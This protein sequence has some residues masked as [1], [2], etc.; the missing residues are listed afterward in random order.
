MPPTL[1]GV[2][3]ARLDALPP[4]ERATLAAGF[5]G[6]AGV[7]G[8][9]GGAFGRRGARGRARPNRAGS[10]RARLHPRD[11]R[12]LASIARTLVSLD[13]LLKKDLTL[14]R[15][16]SSF[17]GTQE[18][19]FKHALLHQ[20]AYDSVLR[21]H[22]RVYHTQAAEWLIAHSG[23]RVGEYAGLIGEHFERAGAPARAAEWYGRAAR[24]A[25]AIYASDVAVAFY[26]KVLALLPAARAM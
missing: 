10:R 5:G 24:Q 2:L 3:Q 8:C 18:Y 6:R 4:A 9:G 23:E 22:R 12:D 26:Q 20:V 19:I 11:T 16:S 17:T 25:Q 15:L 14:L 1:T 21:R 13:A 7:L